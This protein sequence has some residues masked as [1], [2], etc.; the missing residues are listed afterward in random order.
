MQDQ[1]WSNSL[2]AHTQVHGPQY[3][4]KMQPEGPVP[5]HNQIHVQ[6]LPVSAITQDQLPPRRIPIH[7]QDNLQHVYSQDPP[8]HDSM[9]Y[10]MHE[11]FTFPQ[12]HQTE[13]KVH[14]NCP[15]P[16]PLMGPV[17]NQM[18]GA[19]NAQ[20][21]MVPNMIDNIVYRNH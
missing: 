5:I 13:N 2:L 17:P 4:Y 10:G 9:D 8:K 11:Q 15:M 19:Y 3:L 6:P 21:P 7:E 16:G 12:L 18:T 14:F 20:P 1:V